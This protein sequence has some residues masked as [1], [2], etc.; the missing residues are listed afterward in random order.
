MLLSMK[1]ESE[2]QTGHPQIF[3]NPA[4]APEA[5]IVITGAF[6]LDLL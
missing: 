1:E 5:E 3:T 6:V 4:F 2:D